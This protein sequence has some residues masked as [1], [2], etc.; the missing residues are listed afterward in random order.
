MRSLCLMTL[1]FSVISITLLF[2]HPM[3][4]APSTSS[5]SSYSD[6][7]ASGATIDR[8]TIQR[9]LGQGGF[10]ITYLISD[11]HSEGERQ[12]YALKESMPEHLASRAPDG[13]SVRVRNERSDD[14][15]YATGTF[16]EEAQLLRQLD[17]PHIIKVHRAFEQN[18]TVYF[19]MD[20]VEGGSLLA[21]DKKR[22][23]GVSQHSEPDKAPWS[24]AEITAL[25]LPLLDALEYLHSK[26]ILHRDIKPENILLNQQSQPIL[27]DFGAAKLMVRE[28]THAQTSVGTAG[29]TPIEQRGSQSNHVGPWSDLYALAATLYRLMTGSPP[30]MCEDR[31]NR[32]RDPF[33]PLTM[34]TDMS[35]YSHALRASI[36]RALQFDYEQRWQSAAAWRK[37][38]VSITAKHQPLSSQKLPVE[39]VVLTTGIYIALAIFQ[40]FITLIAFA[41]LHVCVARYILKLKQLIPSESSP[42]DNKNAPLALPLRRD[43]TS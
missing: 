3:S 28:H 33:V 39:I 30:A 7:L 21:H 16:L 41:T 25:L 36:D 12:L 26:N 27:V 5:S 9:K 34:R 15:A 20:Y 31:V 24:E 1:A 14:Y 40:P 35:H 10:G 2:F 18:H 13:Q 38:L 8:Y 29:Y 37:Q 19:T 23:E 17:H 32:K 22:R 4:T 6:A 43:H 11:P 42:Q